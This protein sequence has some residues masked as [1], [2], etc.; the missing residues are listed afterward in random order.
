MSDLIIYQ[1]GELEINVSLKNETVWLNRNQIAELFNRDVK[2]IGKHINNVFKDGELEKFSVVA[3][4]ATTASDGKTYN[5]E[6]YN[7]DVII[8]AGYRVK[9]KK[10]VHFRQ[11]ATK[12]LKEYIF[13]GFVI[14]SEKIT[15]QRLLLLEN[16][17]SFIKTH[18][19]DNSLK[20]KKGIFYDGQIFDAYVFI[21]ALIRSSL[22][23]ILL[24]DNYIDESVLTLF[25][26]NR[27]I[28]IEIYTQTITKQLKLDIEK[29]N[30]QYHNL[31]IKQTKSFHD[32]FLIIDNKEVYHIGASLKDLGKKVFA[33][34]KIDI[35]IDNIKKGL[36]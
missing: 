18:V 8:S 6:H 27:D 35:S 17:V 7:L 28:Q 32:R 29:Y 20:L 23:S 19:Q 22:N 14:N 13:N 3:N 11:W 24:I 25:S 2:T 1:N 5:V 9:S 31:T 26:K 12:V 36:K 34:S 30:K 16:D 33:F 21:S 4:F 10:A 15:Q